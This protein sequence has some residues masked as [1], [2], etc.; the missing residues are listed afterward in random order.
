MNCERGSPKTKIGIVIR[1]EREAH[2]HSVN[3]KKQN[4]QKKHSRKQNQHAPAMNKRPTDIRPGT[5]INFA[6]LS[7]SSVCDGQG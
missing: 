7:P 3:R 5:F 1:M 4:I 6:T 2:V